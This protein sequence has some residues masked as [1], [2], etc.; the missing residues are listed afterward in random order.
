MQQRGQ[1]VPGQ[2]QLAFDH[3]AAPVVIVAAG[4]FRSGA[5]LGLGSTYRSLGEYEKALAYLQKGAARFP[6][7]N[8]FHVFMAMTLYNLGRHPEAME[9]LLRVI[10]TTTSDEWIKRYQRALLFYADKLDQTWTD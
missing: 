4:H 9:L 1:S 10:A 2:A 5:M 6:D 7:S 8:E 3:G